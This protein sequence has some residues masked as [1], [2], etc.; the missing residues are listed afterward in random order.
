MNIMSETVITVIVVSSFVALASF[1]GVYF[2]VKW[3]RDD[4]FDFDLGEEE[5]NDGHR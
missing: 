1:F 3:L 4:G 2:L 5:G